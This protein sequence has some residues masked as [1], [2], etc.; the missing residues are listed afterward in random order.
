[1]QSGQGSKSGSKKGPETATIRGGW[2]VASRNFTRSSRAIEVV[3]VLVSG[4]ALITACSISAEF[5]HHR[6]PLRGVVDHAKRRHRTGRGTERFHHQ[7]RGAERKAAAGAEPP[8]QRFQFDGGVLQRGDKEQRA[9]LVA[10][11]Q[12]LGVAAGNAAAQAPRLLDREQRRIGRA[13]LTVGCAMPR[14]SR[15]AKSS[16]DVAAK[17]AVKG[18]V[19]PF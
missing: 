4:C 9:L 12:V 8:V 18:A 11:E 17:G 2:P 5:E 13:R 1:M 15:A 10:K 14:R 7:V 19:M 16:A 3:M 6:D